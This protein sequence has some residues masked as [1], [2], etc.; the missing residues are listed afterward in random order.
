M[1]RQCFLTNT[2]IL[3]NSARLRKVGLDPAALY[4]KV[5]E[6]PPALHI[7]PSIVEKD[8]PLTEEEHD[9]L[10]ALSPMYDQL[11]NKPIWW[12]LE[13]IPARRWVRTEKNKWLK[14]IT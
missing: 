6:R 14:E 8:T 1:I 11:R 10:D 5:L 2:G 3:F 7:P 13:I 4:P 12:L 9:V